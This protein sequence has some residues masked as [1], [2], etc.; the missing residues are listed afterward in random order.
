LS[1]KNAFWLL[2][3]LF[4]LVG[5]AGWADRLGSGHRDA[6]YGSIVTWGLWVAAYIYFIGLSAGSFLI[7]SLV[8]VFNVKRFERIGRLAVFTAIVTLLM[9]LLAIWADLGHM[10]RAWHVLIFPN[11]ESP[12]AWMI[13]LYSTYFLL[14]VAEMWFLLRRD[15][16]TG[17][18]ESGWKS[19]VYRV[20]TFGSK[21]V[22]EASANRDRK[23]V[24]V[25]ATIG[26]PVAIMFHGGVGTLFGVVAARPLWNTGLFP[27]LFL[28]SALASG[29]ALLTMITAIFQD[30]LNRNRDIIVTLGKVIL[31]L[32]LLDIL[33]QISEYLVAFRSGIPGHIEGLMLI[34]G[35]T[36]WW[37]FWI[38]QLGIG[39][40]IPLLLLVLPMTRKDAR[41]VSLA[42]LLIALGFIGVRLNI[43]IPGLAEE[44]INGITQ[45]ISTPRL[46]TQYFP[47]PMEW[48]LTIGIVGLGL[49]LFG[50]GEM[51]L[52]KEKDPVRFTEI[53]PEE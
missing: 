42:G 33:F 14:L 31:G 51:L 39:T 27:I 45:A 40:L 35:G 5:L 43:V 30:G 44:E 36:Y 28:L 12:M 32:L 52:P 16:V 3:A 1:L 11:F 8:Y 4:F 10:E 21:N 29:G 7:S 18:Q 24:R 46:T 38:W 9:A 48:L 6:N 17:A 41:W 26:V 2:G 20:L 34:M 13:W 49:L 25:L 53:A 47:S 19:K 15:M 50:L 23:I 37:V 22:S